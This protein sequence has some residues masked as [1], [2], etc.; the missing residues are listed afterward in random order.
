M[1]RISQSWKVNPFMISGDIRNKN[2][3]MVLASFGSMAVLVIGILVLKHIKIILQM[4]S[5]KTQNNRRYQ[6]FSVAN[7]T[8]LWSEF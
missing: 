6:H 8:G 7:R 1:M 5:R 3:R 4:T 2:N